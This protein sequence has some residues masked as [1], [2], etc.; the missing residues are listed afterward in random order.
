MQTPL[1]REPT[2]EGELGQR[3]VAVQA[4]VDEADADALGLD[5]HPRQRSRVAAGARVSPG[6]GTACHVLSILQEPSSSL[7]QLTWGTGHCVFSLFYSVP[8]S[9]LV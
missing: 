5:L 2:G 7:I 4:V 3:N 9:E 1:V 8:G 6:S